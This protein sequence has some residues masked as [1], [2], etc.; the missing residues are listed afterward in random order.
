MLGILSHN[1]FDTWS[2]EIENQEIDF[3]NLKNTYM[4]TLNK[5]QADPLAALSSSDTDENSQY[6]T[7]YYKVKYYYFIFNC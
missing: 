2:S 1:S 3:V 4:P 7:Q 5:I 6:W